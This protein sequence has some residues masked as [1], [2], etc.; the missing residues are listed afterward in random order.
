MRMG[1]LVVDKRREVFVVDDFLAVGEVLEADKSLLKR[2]VAELVAEL[3]QL[4]LKS[5]AAG[6]LA[7][8]ER[9]LADAD[10]LRSHDL[11]SPGILQHAVLV[12][13]AFMRKSV[14]P[15]DRLVI[16]HR[17]GADR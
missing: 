13:T 15:D 7:H 11:V 14:S 5:M 3:L 8:D 2:V 4:F 1:D 17:E 6:M 9:C 10:A 12:D 16:L